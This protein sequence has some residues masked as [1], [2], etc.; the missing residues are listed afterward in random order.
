M[1]CSKTARSSLKYPLLIM[2]ENIVIGIPLHSEAERLQATLASVRRNTGDGFA[3]VLLPD[4]PDAA[5]ADVLG[6]LPEIPQ[7]AT[8]DA[9]GGAA[10][11]N[12]LAQ[13]NDADVIVLLENGALVG[14]GW[15]DLL[16]AALRA[17]PRNGLA[18]PSTNLCWNEQGVFPRQTAALRDVAITAGGVARRFHGCVRTLDP[19]YSLADFCYVVRREVIEAI[20]LADEGYGLGPCWEMDY[21]IRAARAGWRGVWAGAAYVHRTP[22]TARRRSD[23]ALFFEASKR[24]YQD[25]FCGARLRGEKLDYRPHCRGD[26]CPNFAPPPQ[27]RTPAERSRA[28]SSIAME[29]EWPLVSCIMPTGDRLHFAK[30]AVRYF[31]RQD[32]PNLELVILDSGDE[33]FEPLLDPRLRLIRLAEKKNTGAKRNLACHAAKGD[34]IVHWDDDDWYP[35]NRV[36]RQVSALRAR[37]A[38]ICGTSA[39]FYHDAN[40][41]CAWRY[42]YVGSGRSW[43]AGNTL[44]Y[45]KSWWA[46]HPFAEVQVG[47][48]TRFVWSADAGR[49]C[50][51][52]APELCVARIH[53]GNTSRKNPAAP[54]WQPHPVA[55][56]ASLLGDEWPR[57]S[58]QAASPA[59]DRKLPLASCIMPTFNRRQ[60]V[61]LSLGLFE[62][63]D[64]PAR[65]L[66]VVDDGTDAIGDLV[67]GVPG[68]VYLRLAARASIGEKRNLACAAAR[69]DIIAHWDDDD[70]YA[71]HR[72]RHQIVPLLRGQADIT[73]LE[74]SCVAELATGRFWRTRPELHRR[75]F[76][77]DVH[78]GT[79]V[80]WKNLLGPGVA[81]PAVNLAEDAALL[82][83]A[84]RAQ[85]RVVRVSNDG[86]FVYIRHGSNAWQFEA[87]KF[88]DP[89]GWEVISSPAGF[90]EEQVAAYRE[91]AAGCCPVAVFGAS[92]L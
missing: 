42:R 63:Q 10:C 8:P 7:L 30:E 21:N 69:G 87:G 23:E 11:F 68:V 83:R 18:G 35:P 28:P 31:L 78:G 61:R 36:S 33:P 20:G 79:L 22:S 34:I 25:K 46:A 12:R 74:N 62:A 82:G 59:L 2:G 73:G 15:L 58:G 3:L 90:S 27:P 72:L 84:V 60:F 51:L 54:C 92:G 88:L 17:N 75:M 38:E 4:G 91:A 66:I 80:Y 77:G 29:S 40:A 89:A 24:R 70:W 45:R 1:C 37:P 47:E 39:L 9:R 6:R 41:A 13:F 32:Y 53:P 55:E 67:E 85:K 64:Y 52:D 57:F 14:P 16:L 65:E 86:L 43:V 49:I 71:P 19:L 48:D 50:D 81:Y 76:V 56:L 5:M 26:A 44:A